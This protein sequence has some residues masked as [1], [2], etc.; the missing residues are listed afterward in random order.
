ADELVRLSP[1]LDLVPLAPLDQDEPRL[2]GLVAEARAHGLQG[3]TR[4]LRVADSLEG[5]LEV[6]L[7]LGILGGGQDADDVTIVQRCALGQLIE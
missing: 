2:V 5:E 1:D 4:R 7:V 3:L 6:P